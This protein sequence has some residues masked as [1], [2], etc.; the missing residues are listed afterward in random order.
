[1]S[2]SIEK[3]KTEQ[4]INRAKLKHGD[5]YDYSLTN[6]LGSDKKLDIICPTHGK[7]S[8]T[9]SGHL[10]YGCRLCSKFSLKGTESF[11]KDAENIHGKGTYD[12]S[13]VEY[14]GNKNK[15]I[16]ICPIHG[17]FKQRPNNHVTKKKA[18]GCPKCG[19]KKSRDNKRRSFE[20][21][22]EKALQV[23]GDKYNYDKVVYV[24]NLK[25]VTI[26]CP[27][28]GEFSQIPADHWYGRGCK[29]CGNLKNIPPWRRSDFVKLCKGQLATFY[30]TEF[31]KGDEKFIKIG[32]TSKT[33]KERYEKDNKIPYNYK[34][35]K[36]VN[37]KAEDVWNLEVLNKK[38]LKQFRYSPKN[39]FAG[40]TECF[41]LE[42]L[43]FIKYSI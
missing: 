12:Y 21:F 33:V 3:L 16:I 34:I 20:E 35:L 13:K 1:M 24:S 2:T 38:A 28:H 26:I 37:L 10:R 11:I 32:I 9:A 42:C 23:H 36:E 22:K 29:K 4:F 31:S 30:V 19:D 6:F 7:F 8:Q 41:T 17:E 43:P 14:K 25:K 39:I 40:Y 5:K 15:V 18:Q 27:V